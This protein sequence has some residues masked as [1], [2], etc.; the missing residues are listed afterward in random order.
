MI[1]EALDEKELAFVNE[2]AK[3]E[4]KWVAILNYGSN[5]EIIVSSGE[6]IKEARQEAE[7]R[8]FKTV[9]FFKVPPSDKA[10]MP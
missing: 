10:L 3:Y 4:G 9:T 6:S 2:L 5:D 1:E 8:G 7:A